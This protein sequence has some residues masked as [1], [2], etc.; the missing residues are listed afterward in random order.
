[1]STGVQ[2]T[3]GRCWLWCRQPDVLVTW[4]GPVQVWGMHVP[5]YA[6]STCLDELEA[7][8]WRQVMRQD[9]ARQ[10]PTP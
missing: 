9:S 3:P 1:M 4:I 6:C 5:M 8:A 7:M 2:W 10:H